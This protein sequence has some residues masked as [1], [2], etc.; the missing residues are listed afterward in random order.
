MSDIFCCHHV[1]SDTPK[2][3]VAPVEKYTFLKTLVDGFDSYREP[4][5]R[6][7]DIDMVQKALRN[8]GTLFKIDDITAP[9]GPT[10]FFYYHHKPN[11]ARIY[12]EL[13]ENEFLIETKFKETDVLVKVC[14]YEDDHHHA[15]MCRLMEKKETLAEEGKNGICVGTKDGKRKM[16]P[17]SI[18]HRLPTFR[19][20]TAS[21]NGSQY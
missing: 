6:L 16:L 12:E 10:R 13:A 11:E 17:N 9:L 21:S 19:R 4:I 8:R 5:P 15:Y 3:Q 1:I 14:C 2:V 7:S 20:R 18:R